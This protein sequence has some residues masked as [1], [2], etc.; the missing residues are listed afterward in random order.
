MVAGSITDG[1]GNVLSA[2][3]NILTFDSLPTQNSTNPVTSGGLYNL[4]TSFGVNVS[5]GTLNIPGLANLQNQVT[6]LTARVVALEA[7]VTAIGNPR[8]ISDDDYPAH[9]YTYGIKNDQF[10]I[11][12]IDDGEDH[13]DDDDNE[14]EEEVNE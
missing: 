6:A 5:A 13:S 2:K 3:Q 12:L 8:Q 10:Y 4:F 1:S 7:A 14:E 9:I 11:K